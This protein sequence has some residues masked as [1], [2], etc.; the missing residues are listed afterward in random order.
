MGW[1]QRC[2]LAR[3]NMSLGKGFRIKEPHVLAGVSIGEMNTMDKSK[4]GRKEFIWPTF[5]TGNASLKGARTA[6]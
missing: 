5:L 2:S 6:T 3:G 1:F 4:L